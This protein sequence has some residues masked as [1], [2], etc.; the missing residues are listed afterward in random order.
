MAPDTSE[1]AARAPA[2]RRAASTTLPDHAR[3]VHRRRPR[4]GLITLAVAPGAHAAIPYAPCE[5]AGFQCGQL[6][7]P[8]DRT[9]A[10]PA[11]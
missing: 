6:A 2:P 5:P 9:G 11:R 3:P 4:G 1:R 8:L 7:V 10:V